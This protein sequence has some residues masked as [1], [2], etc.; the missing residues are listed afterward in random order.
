M[1][2]S[3]ERRTVVDKGLD[4]WQKWNKFTLTAEGAAVVGGLL[5][6][7][8]WLVAL[9]GTGAAVDGVQI[10]ALNEIKDRRKKKSA[11]LTLQ[12]TN[13]KQHVLFNASRRNAQWN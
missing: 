1:A 5:F 4:M 13:P 12:V 8:P 3:L 9:G 11:A 10:F 7:V 6:G 2:G